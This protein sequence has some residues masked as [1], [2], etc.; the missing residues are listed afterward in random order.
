MLQ[1]SNS[2]CL[3]MFKRQYYDSELTG[4]ARRAIP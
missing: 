2:S 4:F 3:I 1:I